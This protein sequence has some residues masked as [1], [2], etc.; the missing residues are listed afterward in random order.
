M[1]FYKT[2][3]KRIS[4][5]KYREVYDSAFY[6]YKKIKKQ[7]KRRPYIRSSYFAKQKIFIDLFKTHLH[8]KNWRD[9]ARRARFFPATIELLRNTKIPPISKENPNKKHEIL[10]RFK[11][12]TNE[13]HI[14]YVQVREDKRTGNK[15]LF[16][17]FPEQKK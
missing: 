7:S 1:Q 9:R 4:G 14:F 10:H 17:V 8:Q 11:G 6:E 2:K 16:S 12:K 5:T 13:G 3:N 15:S